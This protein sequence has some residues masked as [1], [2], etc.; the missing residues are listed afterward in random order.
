MLITRAASTCRLKARDPV[1][2]MLSV[3]RIMKLE[4]PAVPGVPV[5]EPLGARL[6]PCGRDPEARAKLNPVPE[7]PLA[8]VLAE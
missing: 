3:A 8:A 7:P 1:L 5:I 4:S 2:P 6:K